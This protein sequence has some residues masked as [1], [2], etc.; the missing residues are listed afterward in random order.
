M[1]D[2]WAQEIIR[3][4]DVDA[5]EMFNVYW[6]KNYNPEKDGPLEAQDK[7]Y[8]AMIRRAFIAGWEVC[9]LQI[10]KRRHE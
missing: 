6:E 10:L 4:I 3:Q 8:L 7:A 2:E 5:E 1:T 9:V